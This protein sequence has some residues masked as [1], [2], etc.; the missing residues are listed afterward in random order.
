MNLTELA[1]LKAF[2]EITDSDDDAWLT[3]CIADVSNMFERYL[4]RFVQLD[5]FRYSHRIF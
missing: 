3:Q 4:N 1:D 2:L 5:F